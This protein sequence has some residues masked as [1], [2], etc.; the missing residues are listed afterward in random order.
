MTPDD[1]RCI[2]GS[3]AFPPPIDSRTATQQAGQLQV[4][5]DHGTA[6]FLGQAQNRLSGARMAN[7][8][9]VPPQK[10]VQEE[11]AAKNNA[12]KNPSSTCGRSG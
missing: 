9:E 11:A 8:T 3:T 5:V 10:A 4:G 12:G 2:S 7:T 6:D 1:C